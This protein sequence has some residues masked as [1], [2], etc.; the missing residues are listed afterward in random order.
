MK[1][2]LLSI[3]LAICMIATFLPSTALAGDPH[4]HPVDTPGAD[5]TFTAVGSD[6]TIS[7]LSGNV[8]LDQDVTASGDITISSGTVNLCLNGHVLNLNGKN[9]TVKEGATLNIYDCGDTEHHFIVDDTG[10]WMLTGNNGA[11]DGDKTLT[12]GV[13][14]GGIG[15]HYEG[16]AI[17]VKDSNSTLHFYG[18]NIAGNTSAGNGG[19]VYVDTGSFTMEGGNIAG[20]TSAG[21]GGGVYV[22]NGARFTMSGGEIA[23][24][25]AKGGGGGVAVCDADSKFTMTGGSI[26]GNTNKAR[27]NGGGGVYL[28]NHAEFEMFSGEITG[29]TSDQQSGG[30]H[31]SYYCNFTM[32]GG[33]ITGN[34]G[35]FNTGGIYVSS[36]SIFT[37]SGG[38]ITDN[39]AQ[40]GPGGGIYVTS[41]TT[42]VSG[43]PTIIRNT[44]GGATNNVYLGSITQGMCKITIGEDGLQEGA[45]IGVSLH[46]TPTTDNP[47]TFATNASANDMGYFSSDNDSYSVTYNDSEKVLQ[48][49]ANPHVHPVSGGTE[50]TFQTIGSG[51]FS[52]LKGDYYL[53]KDV[54][55][56]NNNITVT[57]PVNLCLNGHVLNLNYNN[58]VVEETATLNICDCDNETTPHH[59]NVENT[60]KWTLTGNNG[61]DPG[62]KTLKGG[63]IAKGTAYGFLNDNGG[64]ISVAGGTL[65]LYAGSIVGNMASGTYGG[66]V[67]VSSGSFN[68]YGG[69]IVGNAATI[70]NNT[71]GIG[72]GV[73]VAGGSFNMSGGSIVG[74]QATGKNG[75][76]GIGGGVYVGGGSF[77]ME[78]GKITGNTSASIGGGV[79]V[80]SDASASFTVSGTPTITD[81]TAND[82]TENVYLSDGGTI[83]IGGAL[84]GGSVGV[85]TATAPTSSSP[86]TFTSGWSTY[87]STVQPT[88]YFFPDSDQYKVTLSAAG[89]VQLGKKPSPLPNDENLTDYVTISPDPNENGWYT[90]DITLTGKGS[91]TIG[92]SDSAFGA[93]VTIDQDTENGKLTVYIKDENGNIYQ[94]EFE[95]KLD[96]TP[97]QQPVITGG[98]PSG[99]ELEITVTSTDALSEPTITMKKDGGSEQ[100]VAGGT[101][102]IT[103]AGSYT[104]TATDEAG[105]TSEKTIT[106]YSVTVGEDEQLVVSGGTITKPSDPTGEPGYTFAG[107]YSGDEKWNF[108]NDTVDQ[109]NITLAPRWTLN[110][111]TVTLSA[112]ETSVAYGNTVTLTA[113]ATHEAGDGVTY[114]Y[115]WYKGAEKL[116]GQTGS[117]LKL[118]E[119]SHSG[120][121]TVKVTAT[122]EAGLSALAE[123][124]QVTIAIGKAPG[125][126]SVT[127]AGWTYGDEPNAPT[128]TSDTNPG[129]VTYRYTGRNGTGY[130]SETPPTDAGAYTVY[131]TFAENENYGPCTVSADFTIAP[132]RVAFTVTDN[133][134]WEDGRPK[135]VTITAEGL[136]ESQ[137]TVAYYNE[138]GSEV[139]GPTEPG[140]YAVWVAITNPNYCHTNGSIEKQVGTL[141]IIDPSTVPSSGGTAPDRDIAVDGGSH[142]DVTV[143]PEEAKQGTTVTVTVDPDKGYEV[144]EVVITDENGKEITVTDKGNGKY[145]FVMPNGDVDITVTFREIDA[146]AECGRDVSCPLSGYRDLDPRAWYH[147]GIHYCLANGL[148]DGTG[149]AIFTPDGTTSRAMIATIL[150][151]L[152]GS[153][154]ANSTVL[155][156][157]VPDGLWYTEAVR[158]AAGAGVVT[159][160]DDGTFAPDQ[161]ISRQELA[162]MLYRYAGSPTVNVPELALID[163][164]PDNADVGA[165]AQNALAWAISK[166]IIDG[167]DG[168][169]EPAT[170][171]TR[172]EA[173]TM[174]MRFATLSAR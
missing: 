82:S 24:N 45:Q 70:S 145:T 153:P 63:V 167:K 29:N 120:T 47:V 128:A 132:R 129:T 101:T 93:P 143:W 115:E 68:M 162:A 144:D 135:Y 50:T 5:V 109:D 92:T 159:G 125:T 57:G 66:G 79:Y 110:A 174:L 56:S 130:D 95:Y 160:Y 71:G 51:D 171:A 150:W 105:N 62:D 173:A 59:F 90:G 163:N 166:G 126:G 142:G 20:N 37:M 91:N 49:T 165:W 156:T 106:V 124:N 46:I 119:I 32:T 164:Y 85:T 26:T 22:E 116:A 113:T 102:T 152:S 23:N 16:G 157:D 43:S 3:V 81:N 139:A 100:T 9:I 88:T 65:N 74:N 140:A 38:E 149:T 78:G 169:L 28:F 76:G 122:D 44:A 27:G 99:E 97:P 96:K 158:W 133:T 154:A 64:A 77:N 4:E 75:N 15:G 14:T 55:L 161:P 21:K 141:T 138:D 107:W 118:S 25:D 87:M 94:A 111:P 36:S 1:K 41:S 58:I 54:T 39:T 86:V 108:E 7:G 12:G 34:T 136:S 72:G 8:Y 123:S 147:D 17:Q 114:T 40:W 112:D 2:R 103:E 67:Y 83:T 31:M 19:G 104:F 18:G 33:S 53:D 127:I 10:L 146:T 170:G 134:R 42:I 69:S 172:A 13:I 80:A 6:G 52:D 60:G 35:Y 30:V 121:Y 137:Y 98:S 151:R 48:L 84:T 11:E 61:T 117:T 148:M 168:R 155:F 131:A 89:E 73:Y